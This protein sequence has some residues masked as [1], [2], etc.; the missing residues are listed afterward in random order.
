MKRSTTSGSYIIIAEGLTTLSFQD[1]GLDP[2]TIFHYVV[3]ATNETGKGPDSAEVLTYDGYARCR[4]VGTGCFQR[5]GRPK[6]SCRG[7]RPHGGAGGVHAGTACAVLSAGFHPVTCFPIARVYFPGV[8]IS[9]SRSSRNITPP[10]ERLSNER[11]SSLPFRSMG[12][13]EPSVFAKMSLGVRS[14]S[15]G[16]N[17]SVLK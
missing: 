15:V 2:Q 1:T 5:V 3:S 14:K 7:I 12:G 10:G 17:S 6:W 11:V 4:W 16:S 9:I 8:E 13:G